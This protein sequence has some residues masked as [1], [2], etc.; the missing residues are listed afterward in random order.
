MNKGHATKKV[1]FDESFLVIQKSGTSTILA[2]VEATSS[3]LIA[4]PVASMNAA[5]MK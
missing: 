3:D 1:L 4:W 2:R 5:L